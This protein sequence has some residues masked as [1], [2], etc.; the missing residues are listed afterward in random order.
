MACQSAVGV[1]YNNNNNN[2]NINEESALQKHVAFFDRNHD[3]V[4]YPWETFQGFR[5][6]GSGILLSFFASIFIHLFLSQK[7]R[8][9]KFPSLLFPIE[10]NNIHRGKHGSDSGAYDSEGRFVEAKFEEIFEKYG[11]THGDALTYQELKAMV[12]GI[13]IPKNYGGWVGAFVEWNILYILFKDENGL[14]QKPTV[15]AAFD[16]TLFHQKQ[17]Q[18]DMM[19]MINKANQ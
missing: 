13:R 11:Q 6:I 16:G 17:K 8:P 3:G 18:L 2:I 12:K 10:I 14:L 19:E 9:G 4:I 5:A 1:P 7:T 15:R